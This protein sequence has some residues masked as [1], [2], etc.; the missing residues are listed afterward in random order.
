MF[1]FDEDFL[2]HHAE[3]ALAYIRLVEKEA[4]R[5]HQTNRVWFRQWQDQINQS[6]IQ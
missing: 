5:S 3:V 6:T 4:R 1:H 2:R